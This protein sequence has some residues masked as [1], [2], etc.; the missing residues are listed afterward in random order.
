MQSVACSEI[1]GS[2]IE[3]GGSKAFVDLANEVL[4]ASIEADM[5]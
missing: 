5:I 4:V 1:L 2:I 3:E